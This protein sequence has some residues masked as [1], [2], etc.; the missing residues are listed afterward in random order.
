L[1][2]LSGFAAKLSILQ[3][4]QAST[5]AAWIWGIML[6]SGLFVI[7]TMS[8]AGSAIFWRTEDTKAEAR[9]VR[10]IEALSVCGLLAGALLL[11]VFGRQAFDYSQATAEQL[12][13]PSGYIEAVFAN[14]SVSTPASMKE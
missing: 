8:R 1:P 4:A 5:A 3:A 10:A 2:P 12:L 7:I 14:E 11:M 13:H 6:T 9:P